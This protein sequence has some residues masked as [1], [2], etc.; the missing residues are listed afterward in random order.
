MWQLQAHKTNKIVWNVPTVQ[1]MAQ[2]WSPKWSRIV[3]WIC[4]P[5]I[6]ERYF[7]LGHPV[8]FVMDTNVLFLY[9][10]EMC[11]IPI[12]Y[13]KDVLVWYSSRHMPAWFMFPQCMLAVPVK[14]RFAAPRPDKPQHNTW[15]K[16]IYHPR[17]YKTWMYLP[18]GN[19]WIAECTPERYQ[20]IVWPMVGCH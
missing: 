19:S 17:P 8:A 20:S 4:R 15:C 11:L 14:V 7:F 18:K 16:N 12:D 5:G 3:I 2:F 10:Y 6:S 9:K 1:I 13:D